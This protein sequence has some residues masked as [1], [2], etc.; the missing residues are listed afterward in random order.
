MAESAIRSV[1]CIEA[2]PGKTALAAAL[3]RLAGKAVF[4]V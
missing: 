3:A 4:L 1:G 2:G